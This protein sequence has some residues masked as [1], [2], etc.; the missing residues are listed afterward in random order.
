MKMKIMMMTAV[1]AMIAAFIAFSPVRPVTEVGAQMPN[2]QDGDK[3]KAEQIEL[4]SAKG[5]GTTDANITQKRG[6][7]SMNKKDKGMTRGTGQKTCTVYLTNNTDYE[8][9]IY[10]DGKYRGTT[11]ESGTTY[12]TTGSGSTR[13][14]ARADFEDGSYLY[15]GPS[16]YTCGNNQKGGSVNFIMNE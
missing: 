4:K 1:F 5:T 13:V 14:Y 10:I 2:K 3:K 9:D 12:A 8:I 15:W 16:N 7:N 11:G 6:M